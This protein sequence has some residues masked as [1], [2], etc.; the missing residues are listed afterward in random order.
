MIQEWAERIGGYPGLVLF[1]AMSGIAIPLPED[2]SLLYAGIKIANG[3]WDPVPTLVA[4]L[5][6]VGLRDV[7]VWAMGRV[8][9][10]K[11]LRSRWALRFIG[12]QKLERA[13]AL[14]ER[15]GAFLTISC[16][17]HTDTHN[18]GIRS[19]FMGPKYARQP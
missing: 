12:E 11:L 17:F 19:T 9:G 13:S 6:G 7:L 1:C 4:A 18:L 14:I 16:R 2:V 10:E 3:T 5:L 15:H 8:A